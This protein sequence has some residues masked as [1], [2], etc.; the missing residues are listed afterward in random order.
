MRTAANSRHYNRRHSIFLKAVYLFHHSNY[1]H[2][3]LGVVYLFL[4][5]KEW[6]SSILWRILKIFWQEILQSSIVWVILAAVVCLFAKKVVFS[7]ALFQSFYY[8]INRILA[9]I[10]S[11]HGIAHFLT[12]KPAAIQFCQLTFFQRIP[13]PQSFLIEAAICPDQHWS[14]RNERSH[15]KQLFFL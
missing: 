6:Q 7:H 10:H 12:L 11:F 5:Q 4:L 2:L 15:L 14:Y 8:Y 9:A 3:S 13:E 1:S